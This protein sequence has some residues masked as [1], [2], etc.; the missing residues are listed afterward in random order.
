MPAVAEA[1]SSEHKLCGTKSPATAPL[2][3]GQQQRQLPQWCHLA[4]PGLPQRL[5]TQQHVPPPA[6]ALRQSLLLLLHHQVPRWLQVLTNIDS[7]KRTHKQTSATALAVL[8]LL[9]WR[10]LLQRAST[11]QLACLPRLFGTPRLWQHQHNARPPQT[12]AAALYAPLPRTHL[13]LYQ[14][15][16]L[17]GPANGCARQ[18]RCC[19]CIHLA[20][21]R[22]TH[23]RVHPKH[24]HQQPT[25]S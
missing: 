2:P 9:Q 6:L 3:A 4:P 7:T 15:L 19:L 10:R 8:T 18:W 21:V 24:K 20:A 13:Q 23:P 5:L 1:S 22:P 14:R 25:K 17:G 16:L 12:S 11:V